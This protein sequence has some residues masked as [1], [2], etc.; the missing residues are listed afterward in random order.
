M[1]EAP[2]RKFH[3]EPFLLKA[4]VA[5]A[6][7]HPFPTCIFHFTCKSPLY[8]VLRSIWSNISRSKSGCLSFET[9][10]SEAVTAFFIKTKV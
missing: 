3:I 2:N 10:H 5:L 6:F 8:V 7:V 1:M 9:Q 4:T